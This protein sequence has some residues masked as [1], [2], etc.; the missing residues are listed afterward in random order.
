M[1]AIGARAREE[2]SLAGRLGAHE[3][4]DEIARQTAR[5]AI[6]DADI[7][8]ARNVQDVGCDGDHLDSA[9]GQRADR[10]AH[11]RMVERDDADALRLAAQV[12]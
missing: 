6:V 8:D 10:F 2:H 11:D 4:S 1:A 9:G 3:P 12:E 7:G 5:G